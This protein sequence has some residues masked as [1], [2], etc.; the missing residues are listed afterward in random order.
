MKTMKFHLVR[1]TNLTDDELALLKEHPHTNKIESLVTCENGYD[2]HLVEGYVSRFV[3]KER[4][5][6]VNLYAFKRDRL[7]DE[8]DFEETK[9][10]LIGRRIER[11]LEDYYG[12]ENKV[13]NTVYW[14]DKFYPLSPELHDFFKSLGFENIENTSNSVVCIVF[15]Y[16]TEYD[17]RHED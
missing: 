12:M 9:D 4:K 14:Q 6:D 15:G 1:I 17:E 10:G 11:L 8:F 5:R 2:I 13:W 3:R 16:D 7:H